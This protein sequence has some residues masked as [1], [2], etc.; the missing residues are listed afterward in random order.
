MLNTYVIL[1]NSK[2]ALK[3]LD[4]VYILTQYLFKI[5]FSIIRHLHLSLSLAL[6]AIGFPANILHTFHMP[7]HLI[8]FYL[9]VRSEFK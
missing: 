9:T 8:I 2:P 7:S 1:Y 4:L 3:L 6:I 5:H